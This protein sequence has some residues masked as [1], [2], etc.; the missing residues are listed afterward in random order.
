[1]KD[2]PKI[3]GQAVME[4]V[5]M[6]NGNEIAITVRREDG[7]LTLKKYGNNTEAKK[8]WYKRYLFLR[9][10]TNFIDIMKL[11]VGCLNDSVKMLGLDDEEP[12]KFEKWIAKKTGKDIMDILVAFSLVIGIGLAI[13]LFFLLPNF[14]TGWISSKVE[15]SF[16]VNLIEGGI[17][18]T[19]F[20]IYISLIS[21]MKDIKR[22][23]GFHGAEHKVINAFEHD[24]KLTVENVQKY[25][26]YHKRCGT[27]FL[28]LVMLI[29][30]IVFSLTGW[31][32]QSV[33]IRVAIRLALL[34]VVAA[35]SYELLMVLA[36]FDNIFVKIISWPGK[37]LQKLTTHEPDDDMVSTAISSALS[38]MDTTW[39][40]K[41]V[42][43]GYQ[44]PNDFIEEEKQKDI[45]KDI[46]KE[47]VEDD[48][49][50]SN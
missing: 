13:G 10:V 7:S 5:M 44:F 39:Y 1:M 17:R 38:V 16:V 40:E 41:A 19:I 21:M 14:I 20:V 43:E 24:E 9:G 3:G 4:G 29:A 15:S 30:V 23:F 27:S 32:G 11:G 50:T 18:L 25:S 26:T 31:N 37:Q 45:N 22:F 2:K 42:P 6:R 33:L 36:R 46:D 28:V 35:F 49:T 34:P 47:E 8:P 48:D 12:S